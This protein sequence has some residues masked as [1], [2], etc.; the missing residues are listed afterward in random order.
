MRR[1][2]T[3]LAVPI[4]WL[5]LLTAL[6]VVYHPSAHGNDGAQKAVRG[7]RVDSLDGGETAGGYG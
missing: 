7:G 5:A 4:V 2:R 6:R 3:N 1:I